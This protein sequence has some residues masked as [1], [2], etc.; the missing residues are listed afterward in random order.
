ML[1]VPAFKHYEGV[2]VY[3]DSDSDTV[4][5]AMADIPNLRYG[6]DGKPVFVFYKYKEAASTVHEGGSAGGGYVEFDCQLA[7]SQQQEDAIRADL[8]DWVNHLYAARGIHPAPQVTL[9]P[10]TFVD[11][12]KTSVSLLTMQAKPDG[13]G[14]ITNIIG[15]GKPSLIG[16][17]IA[18]FAMELTQRGAAFM[19]QAFQ[20]PNLP[21]AVVYD[22]KFLAQIPTL[23]MHIWMHAD[24]MHTYFEQVTK[25]IDDSVWGDDDESYTRTVQETFSKY[26]VAGV[27][28]TDWP[29][30]LGGMNGA[31]V[32]KFKKD[33]LEQGWSLIEDAL[34]DG[35]KDKFQATPDADKGAQDD[36]RSTVRN[37]FES[38]SENLDLFY[39]RSSVIKWP[40]HPQ[41][42]MQG[43]LDTPGPNGQKPNKNDFFKEIDL[44][45]PFFKLIRVRVHCNADFANDPINSVKVHIEYGN[46]ANDFLFTDSTTPQVFQAFID[47]ALG[48]KY[49]YSSTVFYKNSSHTLEVP[50]K[51]SN[52]REL[53]IGVDDM[54]ILNVKVLPGAINWDKIN[55]VQLHMRYADPAHNVQPQEDVLKLDK[56]SKDQNYTRTIFAPVTQPYQYQPIFFLNDG[57]QLPFDWS[58]SSSNPLIV[59]DMFSDHLS[60]TLVPTGSDGV[61]TIMVDLDYEDAA[62]HYSAQESFSMKPNGDSQNWLVPLWKGASKSFKYRTL[63]TFKDGTSHQD[64]WKTESGSMTLQVGE[65]AADHLIVN[66]NTD[67]ID[68]T[69]VK[70]AKVNIHY[71]DPANTIDSSEDFVF[72][73]AKS[74]GVTWNIPI[75]NPALKKYTYNAT[76]YMADATVPHKQIPDTPSSEDTIILEVP[77]N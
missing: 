29:S 28:I 64:D 77:T 26:Q 22:I 19:W 40:I 41:A 30:D 7:V 36:Y 16:S 75:K 2:T 60:V 69:A 38:F 17:N 62:H 43:F 51:T 68:F 63:L 34:K 57:G 3:P 8:Q 5:Y 33:M 54:G 72:T 13:S 52:E 61:N 45:D 31:D 74:A 1:K 20:M 18:S 55:S 25:D 71:T 44:D 65:I 76:F 58:P 12:D 59:N 50:P 39:N 46:T 73:Q 6:S 35:M 10:A 47:P 66:L 42:T 4:F 23:N 37:Y 15:A 48:D 14:F 70:L 27:D 32:E 49:K 21:I 24:Q 53:V 11:D 67:L 56:D 9:S